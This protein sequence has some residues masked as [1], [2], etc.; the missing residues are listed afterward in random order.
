MD[1]AR[2]DRVTKAMASGLSR[3]RVLAGLAGSAVGVGARGSSR[4]A[5]GRPDTS[6]T[7][8]NH[9]TADECRAKGG[10]VKPEYGYCSDGREGCGL[11]QYY[12]INWCNYG[13]WEL[14]DKGCGPC[15]W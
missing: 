6:P 14:I 7:R 15:L 5:V 12:W 11:F 2:F 3:R 10:T 8:E 9:I 1:G 13:G 4:A